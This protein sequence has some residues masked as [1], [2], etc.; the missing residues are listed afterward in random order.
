MTTKN[1]LCG[2]LRE[3]QKRGSYD[4][5]AGLYIG[6]VTSL[7]LVLLVTSIWQLSA[8]NPASSGSCWH[9]HAVDW[10]LYRQGSVASRQRSP[11]RRPSFLRRFCCSGPP[12]AS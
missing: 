3:G 2:V 7:G 12:P 11:F 4:F 10:I 9:P 5:I 6:T 1:K 8:R